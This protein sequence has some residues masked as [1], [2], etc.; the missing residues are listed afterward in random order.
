VAILLSTTAAAPNDETKKGEPK[1]ST[2][3]N[4]LEKGTRVAVLDTGNGYRLIVQRPKDEG[5]IA[6]QTPRGHRALVKVEH[7]VDEITPEH[8][9]LRSITD[10]TEELRLPRHVIQSIHFASAKRLL[11]LP[12]AWPTDPAPPQPFVIMPQQAPASP[13][14]PWGPQ[15]A[16]ASPFAPWG[17]QQAP[18]S[19]FAPWGSPASPFVPWAA[20][21]AGD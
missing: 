21:F 8:L 17:S 3:F 9:V 6:V 18:A 5:N 19:P 11:R 2:L 12:A 1:P 13:F 20:R 7:K 14:V 16:P 4:S 10:P 15:Q